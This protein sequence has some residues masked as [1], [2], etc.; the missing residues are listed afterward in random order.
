MILSYKSS[1]CH[2]RDV[3]YQ[4]DEW[5]DTRKAVLLVFGIIVT[6]TETRWQRVLSTQ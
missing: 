5:V 3:F 6:A 1:I 4:L 2:R